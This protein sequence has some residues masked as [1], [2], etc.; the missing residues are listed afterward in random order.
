MPLYR[1]A[2]IMSWPID[3]LDPFRLSVRVQVTRVFVTICMKAFLDGRLGREAAR[4]RDG[5][6]VLG[7]LLR[8]FEEGAKARG[9]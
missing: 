9:A 1:A 7:E 8:G 6:R 3:D 4:E 2:A 5:E